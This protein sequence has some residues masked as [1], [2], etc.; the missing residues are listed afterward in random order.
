MKVKWLGHASFL[1]TS[2]EGKKII[3]DPY[4]IA[5]GINY[6]PINESADVVTISHDHGDHNNERAIKGNPQVIRGEGIKKVKGIEFKGISSH[7]DAARGSQRGNNTIFCFT[8]DGINV[9]HLGDLGHL[10]S[11]KQI[12]DIG[13]VDILL[14]PVGGYFTIDAKEATTVYQSLKAK[15][16]VPMHYKTSKC[17]YPISKVDEFLKGKENA[18]NLN[19]SEVEYKK[20]ELPKEA[21]IVVLQHEL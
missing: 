12:A 16:V 7:H 19:S 6:A 18:R 9:C 10:L 2:E 13:P 3:T 14:I 11:D 17:G 4:N 8:I 21:E 1:V 5:G 15:I 20:A